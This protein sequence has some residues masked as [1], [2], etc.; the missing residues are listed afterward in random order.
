MRKQLFTI[1]GVSALAMLFCLGSAKVYAF[2][3]VTIKVVNESD[4]SN[5]EWATFEAD[6]FNPPGENFSL[7]THGDGLVG[8]EG[9]YVGDKIM[10]SN[11][12]VKSVWTEIKA[13]G[14]VVVCREKMPQ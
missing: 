14:T 7:L 9:A 13:E 12:E 6:F 10:L 3:E 11:N 8:I 2:D 4:G 5:I 1:L